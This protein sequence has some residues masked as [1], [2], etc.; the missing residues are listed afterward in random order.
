MLAAV[1]EKQKN[2]SE[3][4]TRADKALKDKEY[5]EALKE[6]SLAASIKPEEAYPEKKLEEVQKIIKEL[7]AKQL[8][9]DQQISAADSKFTIGNYSQAIEFYQ[10]A[11]KYKPNDS[12]AEN[13]INESRNLI[14]ESEIDAA[15]ANA[16]SSAQFHEE[17]KD[18][19]KA[20]ASWESAS[21]LKPNESL[22]VNKINELGAIVAAEK[23]KIQESYDKLIT[24]A[25]RFY[26]TK[27]FDQAIDS[28]QEAAQLKPD[29]KYPTEMIGQIKKYIE[30]RAIV[31][32]VTQPL[33]IKS[34]NEQRFSFKPVD[35][36]VRRN[37]YVSLNV[38]FANTESSRFFLNY[39]LNE[40][41]NGGIVVR[42]PGGKE[43]NQF[44]IRVSSQ[45]RWYRIDNNWISI[46]AEGSDVEITQLRISSGD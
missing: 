16:V 36:R 9:Y 30:E 6:F 21:H 4:I 43:E 33:S 44:I 3:A 22:P 26:S 27:I 15:Y 28:Y 18:L 29:E 23:R 31:D 19:I 10:E 38:R 24:D 17:N 32:L 12:Y 11:L 5:H 8:A 41:K 42:N 25:D 46:Y 1:A 14:S 39:G 40:Q 2:Y 34:G 7:E 20:L 45:D 37:N 13:R 35:M